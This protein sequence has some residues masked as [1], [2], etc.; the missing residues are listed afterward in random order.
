MSGVQNVAGGVLKLMVVCPRPFPSEGCTC[1]FTG[2][3]ALDRAVDNLPGSHQVLMLFFA[4]E[5]YILKTFHDVAGGL[6]E[7]SECVSMAFCFGRMHVHIFWR[8]WYRQSNGLSLQRQIRF[9]CCLL[10]LNAR[11]I[12]IPRCYWWSAGTEWVC[13]YGL[14]L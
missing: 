5:C 8:E 14:F 10:Q 6:L 4:T 2:G 7:L 13:F 3:S 12:R 11:F 1:T 9:A